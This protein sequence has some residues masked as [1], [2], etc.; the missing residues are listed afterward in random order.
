MIDLPKSTFYYRATTRTAKISDAE[1]VSL[2]EDIQDELP[3]YGYRRVTRE[4][5]RRGRLVNHKRVARVMRA[6]DLGIKPRKRYVCTTD[7]NH[8]SPIYPN[9]Y[10]NVIPA[11]PDMAWL[12]I[13]RT[14]EF[15]PASAI[16]PSFS[17]PA[18]ARSSAMLY[19]DGSTRRWRSPPCAPL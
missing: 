4:L 9:L 14:S 10:R 11:R 13:L 7:S 6:A 3:C 2:I 12:P 19:P 5:C 16:S 15:L 18:V 8:D 1:L 17:T